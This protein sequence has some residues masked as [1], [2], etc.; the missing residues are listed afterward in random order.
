MSPIPAAPSRARRSIA[1]ARKVPNDNEDDPRPAEP[2]A[3][4]HDRPDVLDGPLFRF[5]LRRAGRRLDRRDRGRRP[6][7]GRCSCAELP[8]HGRPPPRARLEDARGG[9]HRRHPT[10][11]PDR[12][13]G[14]ERDCRKSRNALALFTSFGASDLANNLFRRSAEDAFPKGWDTLGED[15]DRLVSPAEL[16]SLAR[17]TQYAHF[18]PEFM[19]SGIW[20]ALRRM[21]FSGGRVSNPDAG[22]ASSSP[23]C[24]KPSRTRR[25]SPASK[26]TRSR[27]GLQNSS[28]R[29]RASAPRTSPR[30]ASPRPTTSSSATRRSAAAPSA[31]TIRP[32]GSACRSTTTSS[33]ARSSGCGRA[34]RGLRYEPLDHGQG[35]SD[36]PHVSRLHGRSRRRRAPSGRRHARG[37]GN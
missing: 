35:R 27:L 2:A 18:T 11:A 34:A 16:A 23:S 17:V 32:A 37:G 29:T 12:G 15:L 36:G 14:A 20:R 10:D 13:G 31:P 1:R 22:P 19:G 7:A 30:R 5:L 24:R 33:R 26:W 4:R 21:G 25:R 6:R 9:Q 28:I 8:S 3:L